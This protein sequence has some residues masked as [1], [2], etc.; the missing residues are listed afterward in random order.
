MALK[1][2]L[3]Y[4]QAARGWTETWYTPGTTLPVSL[5]NACDRLAKAGIA[6][7]A[8]GTTLTYVRYSV[9][10]T[11]QS[12]L[13][14]MGSTYVAPT[15]SPEFCSEDVV[16]TCLMT[17]FYTSDGKKRFIWLRGLRDSNVTRNG[18][19]DSVPAG[20]LLAQLNSYTA[21]VKGGNFQIRFLEQPTEFPAI[22][23][24]PI[25]LIGPNPLDITK[26]DIF[27]KG[28]LPVTWI[29]N[30]T[31]LRI[32]GVSQDQ[33]PG[34][35]RTALIFSTAPVGGVGV[36]IPYNLRN[37]STVKPPNGNLFEVVYQYAD[38]YDSEWQYFGEHKTG[39]PFGVPRGRASVR[40][41]AQ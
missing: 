35:P 37:Q 14:R 6:M 41:R 30:K 13:F 7:R 31:I 2:V 9:V 21:A 36:T 28:A 15:C 27:I 33:C 39:R 40:V 34:M 1:V 29:P 22:V 16:T 32:I 23:K 18:N 38:V 5:P 11:R 20:A 17:K 10:G 12:F 26:T 4:E 24:A 8:Q 19:G 3:F 25:T